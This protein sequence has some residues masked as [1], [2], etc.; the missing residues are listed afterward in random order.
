MNTDEQ[1]EGQEYEGQ[2]Y[3]GQE[4]QEQKEK[5]DFYSD[6]VSFNILDKKQMLLEILGCYK[7][8]KN[9]SFV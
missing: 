2:E 7:K 4:A 1:Y 5:G 8:V 6:R 3:E 9:G